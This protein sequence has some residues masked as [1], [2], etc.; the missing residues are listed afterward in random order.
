MVFGRKQQEKQHGVHAGK[1]GPAKVFGKVNL[2]WEPSAARNDSGISRAD[3]DF[4]GDF[5]YSTEK[6]SVS[7]FDG[8]AFTDVLVDRYGDDPRE[9]DKERIQLES[10]YLKVSHDL[11]VNTSKLNKAKKAY[12]NNPTM[13]GTKSRLDQITKERKS[14]EKDAHNAKEKLDEFNE[15]NPAEWTQYYLV[16]DGVN[17]S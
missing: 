16:S 17:S 3:L 2:D 4:R 1:N 5:E 7:V 13:M 11:E 9:V 12:N 10:A 14:L 15:D 6:R 8:D